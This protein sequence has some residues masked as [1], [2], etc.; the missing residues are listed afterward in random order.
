MQL[1][2]DIPAIL[3]AATD[4]EGAAKTPVAVSVYIDDTAPA[5]CAGHVRAAFASAGPNAR[6]TVG[7]VGEGPIVPYDRDDM[8]VI[9]AGTSDTVGEQ[10]STLRTAGI[11]VMVVTTVPDKVAA[12][13]Q[14]SGHP[15][16]EADLVSPA[17]KERKIPAFIVNAAKKAGIAPEDAVA[18]GESHGEAVAG[19][20]EG[21]ASEANDAEALD[22]APVLTPEA[23]AALDKRMG[24][25]IIAACADKKLAFALA[26]PFV[27][28]PLSL[29]A[30]NATAIQNAGVG[31]VPLIPGA[32]MP[33]MT[34]NQIK[35][36]FQIATAYGE[37][38]DMGRAKEVA[39]VVGGAFICRN[40]ARSAAGLV[41]VIGGVI[42]GGVGYAGTVAMG[43]AAIEYFES[44]GDMVGFA[45][46]LQSARDE[47]VD[48][49][50]KAASTPLGKKAFAKGKDAV[51]NVVFNSRKAN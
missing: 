37:P 46:V 33:I 50:K 44:G 14:A 35:M 15:V 19:L 4:F 10:A 41:P 51:K 36:L 21:S 30:I 8:A 24:E 11:P 25:W 40:I 48:I 7:Y 20:P 5:D 12:A 27:R 18:H 23:A 13:A 28:K 42:R 17:S 49:T 3:K 22:A 26:F 9:V 34:L 45:S 16:P 47:A 2:V 39:A 29:D 38:L 43:R 31:L 1:P 32:D 6:V